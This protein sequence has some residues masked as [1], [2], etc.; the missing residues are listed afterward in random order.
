MTEFTPGS[1][2]EAMRAA[3]KIELTCPAKPLAPEMAP[4]I[5][6]AIDKTT[7]AIVAER[8][9]W[10]QEADART[11]SLAAMRQQRDEFERLMAGFCDQRDAA[12]T[13]AR[14]FRTAL[15]KIAS[16]DGVYGAQA[17]EYK[18][19]ARAALAKADGDSS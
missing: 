15:E 10:C 1:S 9:R 19:I 14:K 16:G 11:E 3:Q 2:E 13:D 4:I 18:Q 12:R 6:A 7:A 8:N 17:H 5:Q